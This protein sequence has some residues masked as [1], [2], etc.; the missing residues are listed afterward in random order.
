[1]RDVSLMMSIYEAA[2]TGKALQTNLKSIDTPS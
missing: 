1:L 2:R